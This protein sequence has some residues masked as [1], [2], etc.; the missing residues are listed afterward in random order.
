MSAAEPI[1]VL[2]TRVVTGTGGG[3]EKT[4]LNSP[5]FLRG[6]RYEEIACYFH[7]PGDPGFAILQERAAQRDCP[8]VGIPDAHPLSLATLRGVAQVCREHRVG[9][10]HGH[11]YKSNLFGLLLRR[12]LGLRLVTTVHGWVK[13]TRRTPLYYWIDRLSLRAYE[14]VIAVSADLEAACLEAGVPRERV[15]L[16]ENGI[17]VDEF[18]PTER[19]C[20]GSI[21]APFVIAASG[22]LSAEKG[23]DHAIKAV[24][25][26]IAKGHK[27]ELRIAGE[28]EE[29]PRLTALALELGIAG[30]VRLLGYCRDMR[31]LL[32]SA[33]AFC[34]SSLRE[35]LPNVVL[36]AM[37]MGLPIVATRA[38]G[39]G[40][41]GRHEQDMLLVPAG[42]TEA[43]IAGLERLLVD[44][45][46]RGELGAAARQRAESELSFARRMDLM[47]AAYDQLL[48]TRATPDDVPRP[49]LS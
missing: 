34:L 26:L 10:W 41:F 14:L 30:C 13:H 20:R 49:A 15:L 42:D 31:G 9:I 45:H 32:D 4:I 3:P 44:A 18:R 22:R 23:F 6:T 48:G 7:P 25:R 33:D 24:A 27:V 1:K 46:L 29:K 28:G 47:R 36:E 8:L 5:R 38:G 16:I 19:A 11:D 35:G 39:M 2:H 40:S 37:A 21:P 43:L 17:D 12:R